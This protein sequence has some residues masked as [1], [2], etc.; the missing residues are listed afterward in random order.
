ME[1]LGINFLELISNPIGWIPAFV[2]GAILIVIGATL[3]DEAST[4]LSNGLTW[5]RHEFIAKVPIKAVRDWMLTEQLK[6]VEKTAK[7]WA[8]LAEQIRKELK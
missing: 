4:F 8:D 1:I 6:S 5:V 7:V 3:L 2:A